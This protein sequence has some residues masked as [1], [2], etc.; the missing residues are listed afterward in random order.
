MRIAKC[1]VFQFVSTITCRTDLCPIYIQL[2]RPIYRR[3]VTYIFLMDLNYMVRCRYMTIYNSHR[4]LTRK[5]HLGSAQPIPPIRAYRSGIFYTMN[6]RRIHIK[7]E[8]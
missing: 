4:L 5:C 1:N 6:L 3:N 2:Y 8:A 7:S